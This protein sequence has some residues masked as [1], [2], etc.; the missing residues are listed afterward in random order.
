MA[1]D[2]HLVLTDFGLSKQFYDSLTLEEQRTDTFCGT[3]EYLAPE[4]LN[5]QPY[6]YEVD[7]WS[8]GTVLY[9]MLTGC[10]PFWAENRDDMYQ[11]IREDLLS[12]PGN[13]DVITANFIGQLL[14]RDPKRRLGSGKD[15]AIMVRSH[16]YFEGIDWDLIYTKRI[17]PPYMPNLYS[18]TDFSHF[19]SEFLKE[20]PRLSPVESDYIMSQ[21]IDQAFEGYSYTNREESIP[22]SPPSELY[23]I[24]EPPSPVT[25]MDANYAITDE[26]G[27]QYFVFNESDDV[28]PYDDY[29]DSM[30]SDDI[31]STDLVRPDSG[32]FRHEMD[33]P[34][35]PARPV[36]A[37]TTSPL[38]QLVTNYSDNSSIQSA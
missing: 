25:L 1:A 7:Y 29:A 38:N 21:S 24:V 26:N 15:G 18:D 35:R 10:T 6:S 27:V 34:P 3:A 23:D 8:L 32:V 14:K 36:T 9:E 19:D 17:R 16:L 20:S 11:R 4:I 33:H 2:G 22:D 12:F 31:L 13:I 37:S 5:Q 30:S 28:V